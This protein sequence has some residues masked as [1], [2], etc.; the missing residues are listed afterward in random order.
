MEM[1][2]FGQDETAEKK[3]NDRMSKRSEGFL[4]RGNLKDDEKNRDKK[5]SDRN[6]DGFTDPPDNN[7]KKDSQEMM[8]NWIGREE[9]EKE[10]ED[11]TA[12]AQEKSNYFSSLHSLLPVGLSL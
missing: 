6:R 8:G 4:R 7:Q 10:D 3:H 5:G 2:C 1:H 12:R 11:E 9:R